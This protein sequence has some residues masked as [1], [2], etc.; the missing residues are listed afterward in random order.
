MRK[1][2]KI[3]LLWAALLLAL[4]LA[5]CQPALLP[6]PSTIPYRDMELEVLPDVPASGLEP[7]G[8][9]LEADGRV[10]YESG[11]L[12]AKEGIDVS[13]YQKEIDWQAVAEDGVEFAMI[14]LGYRGYTQGGLNLDSRFA[15]NIRGAQ[16]AGIEVGV[17]FFSQAITPQEAEEEADFVLAALEGYELSYPVAY[18]WE[19]IT[20]GNG[21][22]TDG[23][24]GETLTQCALAF[25]RRIEEGGYRPAVYFNQE[26]GYLTYD[27]SQLTEYPIW[28]AEY[29]DAPDFHY[30]FDLWQ[31]TD[32]GSVAGIQGPV[33]RNLD[34]APLQNRRCTIIER[35]D[36]PRNIGAFLRF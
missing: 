14:R 15:E 20:P 13:F 18:D 28:L 3:G 36:I 34:F 11:G 10:V 19:F 22:R 8:F 7:A 21:A 24:D 2:R 31:Y 23:M 6:E 26:L 33:D 16:E 5:G 25:C 1:R 17:Y 30:A 27:L 29:D 4:L 12:R 32:S 35:P 9:A